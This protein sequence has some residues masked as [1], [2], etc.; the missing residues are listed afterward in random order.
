MIHFIPSHQRHFADF[1][2]LKTYWLFSFSDYYDP[3]NVQFGALRVFNDDV[4]Q[5]GFGFPAHSHD[6]MEIITLVLKGE[7]THKDSTGV[8]SSIRAGEVQAMTAGTGITHSEYNQGAEPVHLY[9]IWI[10]PEVEGLTPGYRREDFSGHEKRDQWLPI[11]SGQGKGD[12]LPIRSDSS[13]YL[14]ELSQGVEL[15]F[16]SDHQRKKFVY[17]TAGTAE[18]NGQTLT[19]GDQARV[20]SESFLSFKA[21]E[22]ASM[23]LLDLPRGRK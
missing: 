17:V 11:V 6:E 20:E 16:E 10:H 12:A 22:T 23:V 7:L 13:I 14:T 21:L 2:R 4:L 1:G 8:A 19:E 9:Q 3:E 18:L 5:P 15:H